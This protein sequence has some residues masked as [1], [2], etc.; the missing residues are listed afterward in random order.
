MHAGKEDLKLYLVGRLPT[1]KASLIEIHIGQC[2]S[3]RASLAQAVAE[4]RKE[5]Q[6]AATDIKFPDP[7]H[8]PRFQAD[9]PVIIYVFSPAPARMPARLVEVSKNGVK[10]RMRQRLW[11]GALIQV[12]RRRTIALAEVRYSVALDDDFQI[13]AQIQDVIEIPRRDPPS[14]SDR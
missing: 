10:L 12:H 14:E 13:G 7:R 2:E 8:D 4:L 6:Q 1:P 5:T 3:C 9:E 11:P